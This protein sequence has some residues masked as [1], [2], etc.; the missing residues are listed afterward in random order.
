MTTFTNAEA[1]SVARTILQERREE[2]MRERVAASVAHLSDLFADAGDGSVFSF[3]RSFNGRTF[4]YAAIKSGGKW[5][6]TGSKTAVVDGSD[7]DLVTWL[8][9]LEIFEKDDLLALAKTPRTV[10]VIEATA[11]DEAPTPPVISRDRAGFVR[12]SPAGGDL[13]GG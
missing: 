9:G 5:F 3:A 4:H 10:G 11:S 12:T 13:A 1:A 8:I 2:G 7:D 6:S